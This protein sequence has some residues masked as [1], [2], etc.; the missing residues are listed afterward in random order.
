MRRIVMVIGAAV[1]L[2]AS[3]FV[4]A[5]APTPADETTQNASTADFLSASQVADW[6][7]RNLAEHWQQADV[8]PVPTADD[9]QFMRRAYLDLVGSI[10]SVPQVRD[11]LYDKTVDKR[12]QLIE[13]LMTDPRHP[14]HWSRVWQNILIP[15]SSPQAIFGEQLQMWLCDRLRTE[16]RYDQLAREVVMASSGYGRSNPDSFYIALG[17][18]PAPATAGITRV[19]LGTGIG[20]AE[21]HDHPFSKRKQQDFWGMAAFFADVGRGAPQLLGKDAT[22]SIIRAETKTVYNAR[23]LDGSSPIFPEGITARQ[24]FADWL[25]T[26]PEF[27]TTAVNRVWQQ[28]FGR[29]LAT[30]V[31][32]L[33][34]AAKLPPMLVELGTKF[35]QSEFDLKWLIS[36]ICRSKAYQRTSEASVEQADLFASM[37]LKT[38]SSE[39]VFAALEQA[40]M[41][42]VTAHESSPRYSPVKVAFVSKLK[43]S[44]GDSPEQYRAGI[45]QA[46]TLLNGDLVAEGVGL[47][48]SRTLRAIVDAPFLTPLEKIETLY[49]AALS[50]PPSPQEQQRLLDFVNAHSPEQRKEAYADIFWALLNSPEFVLNR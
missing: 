2:A 30:P 27:A 12:E 41:L 6:I 31:D 35:R 46:L 9:A 40:L 29:G 13:R 26:Q 43:E 23:F 39:Q 34:Q 44:I 47:E 3:S 42:P 50:R 14:T 15:P 4:F 1:I 8:Q 38:L 49:F 28:L 11:F 25:I 10:P 32:D 7:D 19:F 37:R 5:A 22:I 20:C 48:N 18:E 24:V 16:V 21:C 17:N 36:G 33:D 45:L